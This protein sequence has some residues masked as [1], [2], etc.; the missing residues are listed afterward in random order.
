VAVSDGGE[1][2]EPAPPPRSTR[3][4]FSSTGENETEE[5]VE[6]YTTHATDKKAQTTK[7]K[8]KKPEKTRN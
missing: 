2:R 3:R 8:Q 4:Y 1:L 5:S 7:F 6:H